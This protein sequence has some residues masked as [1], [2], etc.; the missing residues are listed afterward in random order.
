MQGLLGVL[1]NYGPVIINRGK[2]IPELMTPIITSLIVVPNPEP[3]SGVIFDENEL[4]NLW[5]YIESGGSILLMGNWYRYFWPDAEG[6]YNDLTGR[7]GIYWFDGGVY[8]EENNFG[9]I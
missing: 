3:I 8:D 1:S 4:R 7:Y 9:A 2:F 5:D 6:G